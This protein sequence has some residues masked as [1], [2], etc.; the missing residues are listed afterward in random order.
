M[1]SPT[2]TGTVALVVRFDGN[3]P[4]LIES[5]SEDSEIAI[6]QASVDAEQ[7]EPLQA[8]YSHR[9]RQRHEDDEFG[10]YV[11]ELLSQSCVRPEIQE[12]GVQWLKSKMKIERFVKSEREATQV[13]AQ[14]AFRVFSESPWRTDFFLAGPSSK[15]R[16]RVFPVSIRDKSRENAA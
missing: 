5:L 16:I 4:I 7:P 8:V 1:K 12:H 13:I 2:K 9:E 6:L 14:Y 15:V 3:V 10:N 11:E